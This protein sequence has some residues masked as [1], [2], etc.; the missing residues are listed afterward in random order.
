MGLS[1]A[2]VAELVGELEPLL[3][4]ATVVEVQP[5]PPRDLLLVLEPREPSLGKR[6]RLRV[7]ADP[8]AARVHL[9]IAPVA[10]HEG[11]TAPFFARLSALLVGCE[12]H[13]LEQ[14]RADR[15]VRASFRRDGQPSAAL[16]AELTGRHANLVLVDASGRVQSVLDPPTSGTPAALRLAAGAE[17]ALPPGRKSAQA[18]PEPALV[19]AYPAPE[20]SG[21]SAR[22]APLS[23]RVEQALGRTSEERFRA[24]ARAELE[25]RLE[26]RRANARALLA[27]LTQRAASCAEAER[28][29]MDAELLLAHLAAIP[30]GA[31]EVVLPDAFAPDAPPRRIELDPGLAPR[32]NAERLFARF[33]KLLRTRE[34]LPEELAL[35]EATLARIE[36]LVARVAVEDPA[37]LEAEALAEGLL[38]EQKAPPRK[39]APPAPRLPYLRFRGLRGSEIRVGRNARDND[40]L[41]FREARGND[42][43]LHTA[44]SPG[45]HVVLRLEKGAEPDAEETLDAAHLAVHFSPLRGAPRADVHVARRKDVHKPRKAPPGL[46]TLSGGKLLRLRLEP[47]RLA[48]LLDTRPQPGAAEREPGPP[49][50]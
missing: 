35:A 29:K 30:R 5:L 37:A 9:Q 23:A 38:S 50:R 33:K 34:R 44:D 13:V 19:E 25:R 32:R 11:P 42:L 1:A 39:A 45:S 48:R 12:L 4:G 27:G 14:V 41:T 10:R 47:E 24:A 21:P 17:Y 2:H 43:W 22:L 15:V 18:T 3:R 49:T 8:E 40:Q 46:V 26:R 36:Q 20:D 7:S 28:V 6:L 31:G 16:V